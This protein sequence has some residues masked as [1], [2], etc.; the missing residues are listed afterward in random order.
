MGSVDVPR[1]E[2]R[3]VSTSHGLKG[4]ESIAQALA[5][6]RIFIDNR[7]EGAAEN[8]NPRCC[9]ISGPLQ[10]KALDTTH[11]TPH[12]GLEICKLEGLEGTIDS[13]FL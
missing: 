3:G 13:I 4:Q 7:P 9:G 10:G 6:V 5:W 12:N 2:G 11:L 1:A 8:R